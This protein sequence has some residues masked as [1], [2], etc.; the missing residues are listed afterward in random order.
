MFIAEMCT[1]FLP[2]LFLDTIGE[3]YLSCWRLEPNKETRKEV[4]QAAWK[5]GILNA[6]LVHPF[7]WYLL[8]K[9]LGQGVIIVDDQ[10]PPL[11]EYIIF[12]FFALLCNDQLFYWSH[13]CFHEFPFLY[14]FHKQH[15][16]FNFS[17]GV[18]AEYAHA[19]EG[20]VS[21]ILPTFSGCIF[22]AMYYG[23]IHSFFIII[24][25]GYRLLETTEV[26]SG[27]AF[28][29]SSQWISPFHWGDL[30]EGYESCHHY[31]HHS[32][33]T[34]NYGTAFTDWLYGTD[35]AYRKYTDAKKEEYKKNGREPFYPKFSDLWSNR[36]KDVKRA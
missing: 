32:H 14:K 5:E 34:G 35:V 24:W 4:T 23:E 16:E 27:F 30:G 25:L 2:S 29:I 8:W 28:P 15:H 7:I 18:A 21:N 11:S 22:Y 20:V 6:F 26:H 3:K 12:H 10:I 36:E 19:L 31:F 13:R 1:W 17:R 33:N 9:P